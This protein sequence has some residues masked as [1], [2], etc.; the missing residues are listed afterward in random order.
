MLSYDIVWN[1]EA[2]GNIAHIAEH[3]LTPEDVEEV[4]FNPKRI[5][6]SATPEEKA[7][8]QQ[9]RE[10]IQAE[11]PDLQQRA[12]QKLAAAMPQGVDIQQTIALL[13]AER[14]K[15][16][17]TLSALNESTGIDL[18]TLVQFE[19]SVDVDPT[20]AIL[21]RYADAVGK[22]VYLLLANAD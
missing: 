7:R 2:D 9:I 13:K 4:L 5:Y 6:R 8:H 12:K 19:E 3:D 18:A 11:L 15:K 10:E 1:P 20:I 16:G 14:L 17:L 22:K 21:T